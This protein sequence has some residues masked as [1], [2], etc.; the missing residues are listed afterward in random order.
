MW[1]YASIFIPSLLFLVGFGEEVEVNV[2]SLPHF[3][4]PITEILLNSKQPESYLLPSTLLVASIL[5]SVDPDPSSSVTECPPAIK[6]CLSPP[7]EEK[8]V[9]PSST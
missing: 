9:F 5:K 7:P 6:P 4:A 8:N 2:F 1:I 3:L